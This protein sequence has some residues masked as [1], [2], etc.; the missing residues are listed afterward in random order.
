MP[1]LPEVETMRLG[2]LG[3]VG[4]RIR[5]V[6]ATGCKKKPIGMRP[7]LAAFRRRAAGAR[8]VEVGRVGKRVVL[9]LDTTDRIVLEPRMTG[10]VLVA[11]PPN[12][13]HLRLRFVLDG[14]SAP[15]L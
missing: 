9:E 2:I 14:G 8:I 4:C 12:R 13:E 3:V 1:E 6:A 7:G 11:E 5:Q 10:L 15:E